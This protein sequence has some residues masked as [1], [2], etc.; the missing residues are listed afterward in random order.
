MFGINPSDFSWWIW[1]LSGL[2]AFIFMIFAVDIHCRRKYE[3]LKVLIS[4]VLGLAALACT[5]I[6]FAHFLR[7]A[8]G[9]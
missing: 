1:L 7:W 4:V 3:A 5:V 2:G 9:G 8:W 6:G